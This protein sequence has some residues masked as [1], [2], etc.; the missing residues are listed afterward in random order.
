MFSVFNEIFKH[1]FQFYPL[2]NIVVLRKLQRMTH[3]MASWYHYQS[4]NFALNLCIDT[5]FATLLNSTDTFP[6]WP[7][8]VLIN[9]NYWQICIKQ[10]ELKSSE[11]LQ[12]ASRCCKEYVCTCHLDCET[13]KWNK[14]NSFR[15]LNNKLLAKCS[16]LIKCHNIA[17]LLIMWWQTQIPCYLRK[18]CFHHSSISIC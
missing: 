16:L 14:R 17:G 15:C 2:T 8:L 9:K 12:P 6:F 7:L 13:M 4:Y 10:E 18:N 3:Y 1:Q 11:G 5:L